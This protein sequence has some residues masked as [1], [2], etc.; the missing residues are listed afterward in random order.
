MQPIREFSETARGLSKNPLGI[1]ALFIVM[2]YGF[3]SVVVVYGKNLQPNERLPIIWF[4]VIFPVVVLAVFSW[5]V[6]CHHTKLYSPSDFRSDES[7]SANLFSQAKRRHEELSST[8]F[9][10]TFTI[11]I[12]EFAGP[13]SKSISYPLI[14]F[15]TFGDLTDEI[16]FKLG[17]VVGPYE[18]GHSWVLKNNATGLILK[19]S[20]MI[21]NGKAGKHYPDTR[22]LSDLGIGGG[23]ILKVVRPQVT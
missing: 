5:L 13:N 7:F 22:S 9:S 17:G 21:V 19:N 14:A 16:Y 20:R 8:S 4:L 23:S 2:I 11:D 1:I 18:Y 3:A 6:S 15:S 10:E 12:S